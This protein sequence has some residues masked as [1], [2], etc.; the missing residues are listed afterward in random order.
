MLEGMIAG[1]LDSR[2]LDSQRRALRWSWILA[3]SLGTGGF[4]CTAGCDTNPQTT[5][6][7]GLKQPV[8]GPNTNSSRQTYQV[9]CLSAA[10]ITLDGKADEPVWAEAQVESHFMFPWKTSTAPNTEFRALCNQTH[11]YFSFKVKDADI[12]V[13][14]QLSDEK[15]AVFEDRVEIYLSRDDQMK[16]YFCFE[17][18]SRGRAFDY[19]AAF[20]RQFET[21][22]NFA[23]LETKAASLPHGYEVEGRIPVQNFTELGFPL[24]QPGTRILC[25]L[26]RAEFSHDRSG[27]QVEQRESLHNLGR[28]IEGPPPLEEWMSWVDPK[29][30]EPDFHVPASLGWLEFVNAK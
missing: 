12:V 2:S 13:L 9:Y 4:L 15:D 29:T 28:K 22:W 18:D 24:L 7:S 23:G 5:A 30:K 11:F 25:G 3:G 26:Y 10:N 27:R 8:E 6:S 17:V 16:D 20:Y 14:E 1:K 21:K 19:R